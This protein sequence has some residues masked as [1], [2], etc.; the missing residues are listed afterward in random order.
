MDNLDLKHYVFTDKLLSYKDVSLILGVTR[1]TLLSWSKK[2][3]LR[4]VKIGNR[5]F[6]EAQDIDRFVDECRVRGDE[7]IKKMKEEECRQQE[8]AI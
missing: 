2:H 1:H 6:F 5:I 4:R 8:T 3:G 7:Q